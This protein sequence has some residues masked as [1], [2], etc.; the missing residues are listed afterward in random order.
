MKKLSST[1]SVPGAK[2]VEDHYFKTGRHITRP[3]NVMP[4]EIL[5]ISKSADYTVFNGRIYSA[6]TIVLSEIDT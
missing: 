4:L 2:R 1:N 5:M 3:Q 6:I